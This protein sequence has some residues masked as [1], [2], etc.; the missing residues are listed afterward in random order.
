ML[1]FPGWDYEYKRERFTPAVVRSVISARATRLVGERAARMSYQ[2]AAGRDSYVA[3]RDQYFVVDQSASDGWA[4]AVNEGSYDRERPVFVQYLNPEIRACYGRGYRPQRADADLSGVL[5]A[6]RLAVLS[7]EG[8]LVI[9]ASYLFEVPIMARFLDAVAGLRRAGCIDYASYVPEIGSYAAHKVREYRGDARN[10]YAGRVRRMLLEGLAWRPRLQSSAGDIADDW[11]LAVTRQGIPASWLRSLT[12]RWPARL[13][14]AETMLSDIPARLDGQA[15]VGR[16]VRAAIPVS[17]TP[18]EVPGVDFLISRSYLKSYLADLGAVILADF[19]FG[20]LSCGLREVPGL[21]SRVLSARRADA[22]LRYA[23]IYEYVHGMA[24]WPDLL[25]LRE[26]PAMGIVM[27]GVFDGARHDVVRRAALRARKR[28]PP[29]AAVACG[30]AVARV[31]IL[32]EEI[33]ASSG[34]GPAAGRIPI[35]RTPVEGNT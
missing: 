21:R 18:D 4:G 2:V 12:A 14:D 35:L 20:D 15:F 10:P 17:L 24:E 3:G 8:S 1:A 7:T 26:S 33:M 19:A 27:F 22:A 13:G 6:T 28:Y 34:S 5:H 25:R 30:E 23:G 11:R 29:M 32:A 31:D 9:P 16:F